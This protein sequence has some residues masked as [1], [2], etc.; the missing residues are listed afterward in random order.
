MNKTLFSSDVRLWVRKG[1]GLVY[2]KGV[3][4]L[5]Q[6]C[7]RHGSLHMAASEMQMSYHKALFLVRRT[8]EG[9]GRTILVRSIGGTGGGGSR[10]TPFGQ[11]L[12]GRFAALEASLDRY[13]ALQLDKLLR[14]L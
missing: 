13:A 10:L 11:K 1:S 3:S 9:F 6:L 14:R 7:A 5:L 2:G 8:E 12:V 4:Q